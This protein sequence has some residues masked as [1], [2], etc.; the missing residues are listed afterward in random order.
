M[1][2]EVLRT[3]VFW[4]GV[5]RI[6]SSPGGIIYGSIYEKELMISIKE[7]KVL[8]E[9]IVDNRKKNLPSGH[10]RSVEEVQKLVNRRNPIETSALRSTAPQYV[11]DHSLRSH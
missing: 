11:V 10:D 3:A 4:S 9:L 6:H 2:Q 8:S 7:G 1:G 5:N